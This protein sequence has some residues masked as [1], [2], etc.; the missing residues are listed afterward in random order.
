MTRMLLSV[1]LLSMLTF[2][3]GCDW[4]NGGSPVLPVDP[5]TP[6]EPPPPPPP[7][8]E[9]VLTVAIDD[10]YGDRFKPAVIDVTYTLEDEAIEWTYE[11]D[12]RAVRTD[13]GLLVYGNGD[14]YEGTVVIN[15]E[16]FLVQLSSEPRC[17]RAELNTDCLGYQ[18]LGDFQGQVYYGEDDD[19][20]VEWELVVLRYIGTCEIPSI[21]GLC[22]DEVYDI[23]RAEDRVQYYNQAM[24]NSGVFVRFVLKEYRY[25]ETSSLLTA[26]SLADY[27]NA[28]ISI[29]LGTT[30]PNTCGCAYAYKT[31]KKPGFGW[32]VCGWATD[33][34]EMG[35]SIGLAHG[36]ENSANPA[37]GYLFPEFG[38][39]WM[40]NQCNSA[41]DIMSYNSYSNEFFNSK[42]ECDNVDAYVTDRSYADSA[43]HLNRIRYDVSLVNDDAGTIESLRVTPFTRGQLILD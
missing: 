24:E 3:A 16:P 10:T 9:P 28:D 21:Q 7:P 17:G 25:I 4:W 31:Y 19:Q 39:G 2:V 26:G 32:S 6:V 22:D 5:V 41:G 30:C 20:I 18:Y 13:T 33:L 42:I 43:Y 14:T 15:D 8:P 1:T 11:T 38:H 29:G 27:L 12:L 36:P 40:Y 35:H 37:T 23:E 34:H